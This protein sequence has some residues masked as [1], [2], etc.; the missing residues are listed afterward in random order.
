MS[1]FDD[2]QLAGAGE[3]WSESV[4]KFTQPVRYYKSNDPYYWEVDNIP[5]KQL[6]ENILWLKDQLKGPETGVSGLPRSTFAELQPYATGSSR[7]VS[8]RAGKF[9]GRVNDA[10]NK[11]IISMV[12]EAYEQLP[13]GIAPYVKNKVR[14]VYDD[15]FYRRIVGEAIL[16]S[17]VN[18]GLYDH[19]QHHQVEAFPAGAAALEFIEGSTIFNQNT[20]DGIQNLPKNKLAIW[21]T[22]NSATNSGTG[23][24]DLQQ[25]AT[26]FTRRWGGV[27]RTAVVNV[28]EDISIQVQPFSD[29]DF[30]NPNNLTIPQV[31]F[32]LLFIYTHPIDSDSTTIAAPN[33]TAPATITTPQLGIVRGAGAVRL[34][35][36]GQFSEYDTETN[37]IDNF[38]DSVTY[39]SYENDPQSYFK[40]TPALSQNSLQTNI[41]A[42]LAG[43]FQTSVGI[44]G[45]YGNF[46]SPDDL[47]NLSPLLQEGLE[48]SLSLVGQTVLPVAY[49]IVRKGATNVTQEDLIDIRPFF[50]TAELSYNERSGI[51]GANPPLSLAN[52]AVGRRELNEHTRKMS[53]YVQQY[54][55]EV[56][57]G[58]LGGG[59]GDSNIIA[60]GAI[61]GGTKWGPEGALAI[62]HINKNLPPL[63]NLPIAN[64]GD[65]ASLL[66]NNYLKGFQL[67]DGVPPPEYPGWDRATWLDQGSFSARGQKRNDYIHFA[68][69]GPDVANLDPYGVGSNT[70][71]QSKIDLPHLGTGGSGLV[72]MDNLT[73]L[74]KQ[75]RFRATGIS[76]YSV[77]C[78]Y[79]NCA[80]ITLKTRTA[81]QT[82]QTETVTVSVTNSNGGSSNYSDTFTDDSTVFTNIGQSNGIFI[83]KGP[84][85][86]GYAYFTIFV[87]VVGNPNFDAAMNSVNGY[88]DQD[89]ADDFRD[90]DMFTNFRFLHSAWA[91][92]ETD[93]N[94]GNYPA[95]YCTYPTVEFTIFGYPDISSQNYFYNNQNNGS[96]GSAN[97]PS[98][99]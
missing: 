10:Y 89:T 92:I 17:L 34:R 66:S 65:L 9:M 69:G 38:F 86:D 5:I 25:L 75:L 30:I 70:Y 57:L 29:D 7:I 55:S 76:D 19:L 81:I 14:F 28:P 40:L 72:K 22:G 91:D 43:T 58:G 56:A 20:L 63:G 99:E 47:M 73:F 98:L 39:D 50:R 96:F 37:F 46:P 15:A 87:A 32:D 60:R 27:A 23:A 26:E 33:G 51:A 24:V 90:G 44:N 16:P 94:G 83:E 97:V 49:I 12:K 3:N 8:V 59:S 11:G 82:D 78:N 36:F 45:N 53:A 62:T 35:G 74:K 6:E 68:P 48:N 21:R 64:D 93:Y 54:V 77:H 67:Q 31:R 42:P 61:L 95:L 88:L 1:H 52:P 84:I 4:Y 80:P 2:N 71:L 79:L 41:L 18:N 85:V 13:A